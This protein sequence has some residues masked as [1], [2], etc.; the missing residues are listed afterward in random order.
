MNRKLN[1]ANYRVLIPL[2]AVLASAGGLNL[3]WATPA[4]AAG[5]V[6]LRLEKGNA[7]IT[8]DDGDNNIIVSQ[9]CCQLSS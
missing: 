3:V 5:N 7:I 1:K 9:A 2:I 6:E 4:Q 8:G